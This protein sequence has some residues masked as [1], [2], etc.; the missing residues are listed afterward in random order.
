[1]FDYDFYF[2]FNIFIKD[3]ISIPGIVNDPASPVVVNGIRKYK[4]GEIYYDEYDA[5]FLVNK[6]DELLEVKEWVAK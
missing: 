5:N 6:L 2:I 4:K 1:M 3:Y